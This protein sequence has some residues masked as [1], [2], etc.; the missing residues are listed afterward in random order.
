VSDFVWPIRI[1]VED[2]DVGGI[3]FY[4]N[5]LKFMER[6]RTERIRSLGFPRLET[7]WSQ[8]IFVVHSAEL[9]YHQPARLDDEILV[10]ADITRLGRSYIEFSQ[11][12]Y[13]RQAEFEASAE[14]GKP[15]VSGRIK[16]AC[17]THDKLKPTAMPA[18]LAAALGKIERP[19]MGSKA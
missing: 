15:I 6:A 11:N 13:L 5:Y 19:V 2:T 17:V 3:V 12:V 14:L 16:I 1:Y 18:P 10:T 7:L 4:A 8:V 9:Q